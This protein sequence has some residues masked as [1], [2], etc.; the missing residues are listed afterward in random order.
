MTDLAGIPRSFAGPGPREH[1]ALAH[2][3]RPVRPRGALISRCINEFVGRD[4]E[5]ERWVSNERPVV[6]PGFDHMVFVRVVNEPKGRESY[7]P[8]LYQPQR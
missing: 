2:V 1:L 6:I 3:A 8:G 7:F 5:E 4:A